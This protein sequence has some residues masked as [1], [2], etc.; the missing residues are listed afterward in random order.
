MKRIL[1]ITVTV[2]I[3]AGTSKAGLGWTLDECIRHYG[4]IDYSDT[5]EFFTGLPKHHFKVKDFE[6]TAVINNEG[7]VV[8]IAYFSHVMS[9]QDISNL[10]A[11]NAPKTEWKIRLKEHTRSQG[12]RV[13]W[14]GFEDGTRKY[15]ADSW[16]I[17]DEQ[18]NPQIYGA[19]VLEIENLEYEALK[20]SYEERR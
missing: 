6:I 18:A 20:K 12:D 10:L 4:S 14:D 9:E 13:V 19:K 16:T 5:D 8:R 11:G 1:L 7:K 17:L 3:L 15:L 2:A